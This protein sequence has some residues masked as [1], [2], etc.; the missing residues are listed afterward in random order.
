MK[1][2]ILLVMVSLPFLAQAQKA[3]T[4]QTA[5]AS[6][7]VGGGER[8]FS[9]AYNYQWQLGKKKKFEIGGGLHFTAY[10]G[11]DKY[12]ITA[13][14]KLTSGETGPGVLFAENIP[15]NIDSFLLKKS[16]IFALNLSIN[17]GYNITPKFYAG[18]NIDALGFS[19]GGSKSGTYINNGTGKSVNAK[20][21]SFNALLISDNDL[22]S[23]NSE[24]FGRY[25]LNDKLSIRGGIS[26]IFTEYTTDTK[27]QNVNGVLNDRFRAKSLLGMV[28]VTWHL[29]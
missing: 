21:T 5:D 9:L 3:K 14:A 23:L 29:K 6:L 18:F 11:N 7:M 2:I 26:F 19:F 1:K 28:G 4:V 8:G 20:P 24:L 13:P 16:G 25:R 27:V 22:G 10:G 12:Y 17:L 15:G